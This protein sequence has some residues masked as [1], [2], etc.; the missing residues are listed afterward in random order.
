MAD[1]FT[2]LSQA[3]HNEELAKKLSNEPPYHDWGITVAFYSAIH[4]F[5]CFLLDK[6]ETHSETS[7]EKND[8]G[9][10]KT[11]IHGWRLKLITYYLDKKAFVYF[12]DLKVAS[13]T[14]RYLIN[15]SIYTTS[16]DRLPWLTKEAS[17]FYNPEDAKKMLTVNLSSLKKKFDIEE[18]NEVSQNE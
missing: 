3:K 13:E 6:A 16:K 2:H 14:A 18:D 4:Y 8:D 9:T 10:D 7:V 5:E 12:N 11:S 15:K 17:E 1:Y